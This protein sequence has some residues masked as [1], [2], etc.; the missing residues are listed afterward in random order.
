M[1]LYT[2]MDN[3]GLNVV[4]NQE[5]AQA[6]PH[7]SAVHCRSKLKLFESL[8]FH[9][10]TTTLYLHPNLD[11]IC[12][13]ARRLLDFRSLPRMK[14][15]IRRSLSLDTNLT[16][17]MH[18]CLRSGYEHVYERCISSYFLNNWSKPL[19]LDTLV[20]GQYFGHRRLYYQLFDS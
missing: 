1:T 2:A 14:R 17:M 9:R 10:Y 11:Q 4:C 18:M 16:T 6:V 5:Y 19:T 3:T 15:C 20:N 12:L 7:V 13:L 8:T